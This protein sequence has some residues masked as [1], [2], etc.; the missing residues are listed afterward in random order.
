MYRTLEAA[1]YTWN[2]WWE[3]DERDFVFYDPDNYNR[4]SE[5]ISDA[6]D[7]YLAKDFS[8]AMESIKEAEARYGKVLEIGWTSYAELRRSLAESERLTALDT[9]TNIGAKD[10]FDE[11]EQLYQSALECQDTEKYE[12]AAKQF[13]HAEAIYTIAGMSIA[14]KRRKAAAAIQ[15]ANE[16]IERS[17]EAA[18]Q[19]A[20]IIYGESK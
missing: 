3:I 12:D 9:K 18:R 6:M 13:V 16:K 10:Y 15:D 14:E 17:D 2:L 7:A 1:Y 20:D 11:A 8:A 5:I 4:A 19:A